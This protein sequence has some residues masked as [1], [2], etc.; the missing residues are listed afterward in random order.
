MSNKEI[1]MHNKIG[2]INFPLMIKNLLISTFIVSA[3]S[4]CGG[5]E[6]PSTPPDV[7]LPPAMTTIEG[8]VSA[9]ILNGANVTVRGLDDATIA[10]GTT[11][12]EGRFSIDIVASD[13]ANGFSIEASGGMLNEN[14]FEGVF[15]SI[16]SAT[17][18]SSTA[19][20]TITTTLVS[21]L[22]QLETEGTI[23][24]KRDSVIESLAGIGLFQANEWQSIDLS[25]IDLE[26]FYNDIERLGFSFVISKLVADLQDAEL[27]VENM[28]AL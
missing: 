22:A 24:E 6:T 19:N 18:N 11:N 27:N 23:I 1:D 16:Y 8:K 17:D 26:T 25:S 13:I 9:Q 5:S 12:A 20:L 21:E 28:H 7:I 15:K 4:G 14:V 2:T 10:T 3:L